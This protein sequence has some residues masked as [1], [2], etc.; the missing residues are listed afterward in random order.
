MKNPLEKIT[1]AIKAFFK[2]NNVSDDANVD[3]ND[4]G[5]SLDI[6]ISVNN[7]QR[8]SRQSG[9]ADFDQAGYK[10]LRN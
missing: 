5:K 8:S 4:S 9:A 6:K 3:I 7:E 2:R 10:S 1:D